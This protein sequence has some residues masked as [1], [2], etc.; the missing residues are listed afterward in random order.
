[1]VKN[2]SGVEQNRLQ[3]AIVLKKVLKIVGNVLMLD[4]P[5][6]DLDMETLRALEKAIMKYR[7][8]SHNYLS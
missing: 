7:W 6:I 2:L 8:Y 4:E 5:T 3:R 1:L